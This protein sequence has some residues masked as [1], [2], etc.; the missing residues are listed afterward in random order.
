[1]DG[2]SL[3][4]NAFVEVVSGALVAVVHALMVAVNAFAV[5]RAFEVG[6]FLVA[7][8]SFVVGFVVAMGVNGFFLFSFLLQMRAI[9]VL[10]ACMAY[11]YNLVLCFTLL[12]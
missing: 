11:V 4:E 6:N 9:Y 2:A 8:S 7:A 1:M 3:I 12:I 5:V 10:E